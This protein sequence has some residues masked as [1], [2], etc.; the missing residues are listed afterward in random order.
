MLNPMVYF[1]AVLL[2]AALV[3]MLAVQALAQTQLDYDTWAEQATS[4]ESVIADEDATD[5]ELEALR[6]DIAK[7]R[8]RFLEASNVNTPRMDSV[9]AQIDALGPEP[10][11]GAGESK[12]LAD[13]R[14]ALTEQLEELRAPVRR[15]EEAYSRAD[16]IISE[17]DTTIRERQAEALLELG[18]SPINPA[19][20]PAAI[21]SLLVSVKGLVV[22]VEEN[23]ASEEKRN[24]AKAQLPLVLFLLFLGLLLILRGRVWI[25]GAVKR[26]RK[27]TRKGTG[28]W[29]FLVSLGQIIVPMIGIIALALSVLATG[30][31]GERGSLLLAEVPGWAMTILGVW[32]LGDQTFSRTDNVGSLPLD[33]S[34]RTEARIDVSILGVL[35][36]AQDVI[37]KVAANEGYSVA[38][39]AVL[40]LPIIVLTGIALFR[41]GIILRQVGVAQELD[42]P[43]STEAPFRIRMVRLLGQVAMVVAV[44]GPAMSAIGYVN[45][46]EAMIYPTVQ[47]FTLLGVLLVLQRF[48]FDLYALVTGRGDE[49]GDGLL[50]VLGGFV[51]TLASLPVLALIWGARV[52]DLTELWAQFREGFAFGDTRIAPT[53]FLTFAVVF[54]IGYGATRLLQGGLRGSV[55]PKTK[56][57]IGGQNAI[58][59]GVGYLGIFLA[60]LIA[61]TATGLDLSSLAIVA[62]A[63]SVG[64]GFGLQNIVS[65][66]VAGIILLIERP[67][68]EGDWIEV[69]GTHGTVRSISVRSTRVETFD[70]YDVIIPNADFVSGRVSNYTRGNALG[71]IIIPVGVAYGTDTR[72]VEE[73][74]LRI[75]R[76]HPLVMLNPAPYV[77]FKEFGADSMNFEIRAILSDINEGM[78]VRTEMNHQIVEAFAKEGFEIPFAQRD[79]WL[80]NPETLT[81]GKGAAQSE[82]E[83]VRD[84]DNKDQSAPVHNPIPRSEPDQASSGE[85]GDGDGDT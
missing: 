17:I 28:V 62:G 74:L 44:V 6:G 54:V 11:E 49:D 41:L 55:L 36:V 50:P 29:S 84:D 82:P 51:L 71:R 27:L 24:E 8:E 38:T 12:D 58:V 48:V 56:L 73:V 23:W 19:L 77:L 31:L 5:T 70:R 16:A 72:K 14:A 76:F 75:A 85:D 59:S 21:E 22:E 60:A 52:A 13:R 33:R 20:W 2:P 37:V 18:P 45:A 40:K 69:G 80:R 4:A 78:G 30:M 66:F 65:N 26:L 3:L 64:I 42:N 57:D 83:H 68:S 35:L 63:L 47:T 34:R 39:A 67:I 79:V 53:D 7:W 32:W 61:V 15:A 9:Q 46:G 43:D 81:Q 1:K 10:E 25:G